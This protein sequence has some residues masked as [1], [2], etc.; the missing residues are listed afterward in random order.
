MATARRSLRCGS[1][2]PLVEGCV[3][4]A[5]PTRA[6]RCGTPLA[7]VRDADDAARVPSAAPRRHGIDV[8][9]G[10][11]PAAPCRSRSSSRHP[12]PARP[13]ALAT[14]ASASATRTA[15][16]VVVQVR[17]ARSAASRR[18]I[19]SFGLR[20][21]RSRRR[22]HDAFHHLRHRGA[23]PADGSDAAPASR[24]RAAPPRTAAPG[25]CS[26]SAA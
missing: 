12:S 21:L 24:P 23:R 9:A 13:G 8:D 18:P 26:P 6:G 22:Q 15:G 20:G 19:V 16:E 2:Q 5:A 7:P 10:A 11:W 14:M 25:G 17:A 3:H 4:S 1:I